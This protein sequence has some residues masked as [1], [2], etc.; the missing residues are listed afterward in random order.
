MLATATGCEHET[1]V[2]CTASIYS[3]ST[4]KAVTGAENPT[5]VPPNSLLY[6]LDPPAL[7]D[8]SPVPELTNDFPDTYYRKEGFNWFAGI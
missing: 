6:D 2:N 7:S 3:L 4:A 5:P 8:V 1:P